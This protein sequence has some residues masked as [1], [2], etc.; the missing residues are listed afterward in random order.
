MTISTPESMLFKVLN[1]IIFQIGFMLFENLTFL[2]LCI[3]VGT[4]LDEELH[5]RGFSALDGSN[6]SCTSAEARSVY[7]GPGL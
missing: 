5:T 2:V 6:E 7:S 3:H 1:G 4:R